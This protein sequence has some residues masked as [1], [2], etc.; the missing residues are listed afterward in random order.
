MPVRPIEN[1][2]A[3]VA[4]GGSLEVVVV[5]VFFCL[6]SYTVT[7]H[8]HHAHAHDV[9]KKLVVEVVEQK[10]C[11]VWCFDFGARGITLP[12]TET[13]KEKE[14]K[15]SNQKRNN[16]TLGCNKVVE[17]LQTIVLPSDRSAS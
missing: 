2:P 6:F 3:S 15:E 5:V 13:I 17:V 16:I 4:L 11:L 7:R 1:S 14:T 9:E 8:K 12:K 10:I